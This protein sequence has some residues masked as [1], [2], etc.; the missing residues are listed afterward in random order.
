ML[1]WGHGGRLIQRHV[2]DATSL[3][4]NFSAVPLKRKPLPPRV[5]DQRTRF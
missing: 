3:F 1:R 2:D 5:Q 4:L